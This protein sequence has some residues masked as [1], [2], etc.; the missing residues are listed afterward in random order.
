[1][2]T[3]LSWLGAGGKPVAH[4]LAVAR[5]RIC[6]A[7]P[8]N[9]E[10]RW[11]ETAKDTVAETIRIWLEEKNKLDLRVPNEDALGM[12]KT[13]GCCNRLLVHTPFD[14]IRKNMTGQ[15]AAKYPDTCWKAI[16]LKGV[17]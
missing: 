7:C 11:W 1:V 14:H 2:S 6:E 8:H 4:D 10:P 16:A 13:C 12:C 9:V 15:E 3:L 17:S 5:A